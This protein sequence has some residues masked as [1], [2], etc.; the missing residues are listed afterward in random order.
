MAVDCQQM[1][2]RNVDRFDHLFEKD[3]IFFVALYAI[4]PQRF[5]FAL[6]DCVVTG[7]FNQI[8]LSLRKATPKATPG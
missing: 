4:G 8:C 1:C 6:L 3:V 7:F 5:R 2:N